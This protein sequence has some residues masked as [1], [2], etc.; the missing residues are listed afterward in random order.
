MKAS[1]LLAKYG[2]IAVL[3]R[4]GYSLPS[5]LKAVYPE[6]T[7]KFHLF[8]MAP[9]GYWKSIFDDSSLQL[10]CLDMQNQREYLLWLGNQL[11]IQRPQ[12]WYKVNTQKFLANK[13]KGLL[14]YYQG[15][16][17]KA[18]IAVFPEYNLK[19]WKFKMISKGV[20]DKKQNV[21]EFMQEMGDMFNLTNLEDWKKVSVKH[22]IALRGDYLL[23]KCGGLNNLLSRLYG[24]FRKN[25][26]NK[27]QFYLQNMLQI[28]LPG[29]EILPEFRQV[30]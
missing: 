5:A 18:L 8:Q 7:W 15:S 26:V 9:I 1:D 20:W 10:L 30:N 6:H 13:G 14:N 2:G 4:H 22:F 11:G 23:K 12:D 21:E 24:S 28:L 17:I 27:E 29:V 25:K 16:F 3:K 19:E